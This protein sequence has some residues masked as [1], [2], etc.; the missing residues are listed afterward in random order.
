MNNYKC[1]RCHRFNSQKLHVSLYLMSIATVWTQTQHMIMVCVI[2]IK[3]I[4][5]LVWTRRVESC[6][7]MDKIEIGT[8]RVKKIKINGFTRP[9]FSLLLA[10]RRKAHIWIKMWT[11][12]RTRSAIYFQVLFWTNLRRNAA[13][14]FWRFAIIWLQF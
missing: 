8:I 5:Q 1:V 12:N 7:E 9:I 4:T 11:E 10:L 2:I 6:N 14:H 13:L 3:S